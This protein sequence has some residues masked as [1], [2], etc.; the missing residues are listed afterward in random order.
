MQPDPEFQ[1]FTPVLVI[2]T[3][4]IKSHITCLENRVLIDALNHRGSFSCDLKSVLSI[5]K[6]E[7]RVN[8]CK[9]VFYLKRR[10]SGLVDTPKAPNPDAATKGFCMRSCKIFSG[11][12]ITSMP[13]S[14]LLPFS[15]LENS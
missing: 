4:H 1:G 10:C 13:F 7:A 15:M 8:F 3:L 5:P 9:G 12:A 6:A 2:P 11:K 14:A